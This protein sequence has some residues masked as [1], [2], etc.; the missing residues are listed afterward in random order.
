[1]SI[2]N[3]EFK[4]SVD[5]LDNYEKKLLSLNPGFHGIDEQVD[6][7]FRVS[8]GRLK[9]REGN[10]ENALIYYERDDVADTKKSD[11]ILFRYTPDKALKEILTLQFGVKI[12]VHKTRKIYFIEH[13]K[14]HFDIVDGL[15]SFIEVE[16]IDINSEFTIEQ[17]KQQCDHY[18]N[19]F[20]LS[21][22]DLIDKSYSDL[23]EA[24]AN[25]NALSC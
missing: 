24:A 22:H 2:K 8:K 4:A 12:I 9:I 5:N 16:V 25:K 1:M 13:I 15:G 18:F 17:L 6:T 19:F 3:F 20:E 10:I 21:K 11:I 7:Y 23:I 14:F